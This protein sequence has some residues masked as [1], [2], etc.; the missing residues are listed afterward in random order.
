MLVA[1]REQADAREHEDPAEY[2]D[3]PVEAREERSPE[4][5]EQRAHRQR[6]EDA[7]EEHS[8]LQRGRHREVAEDD[9][10]D[11]Q[12]VDRQRLL[13]HVARGELQRAFGTMPV[14]HAPAKQCGQR[15]P[16]SAPDG[17]LLE[18]DRV[19][20]AMEYAEV[21]GQHREHEDEEGGPQERRADGVG[22]H[23]A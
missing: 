13:D 18:R 14:V 11:E 16:H 15:D 2:V 20:L 12:V 10:E 3:R 23:G 9:D 7:P 8:V 6:A 17:S 19:L 5:D 1:L 4:E 22:T 21:E